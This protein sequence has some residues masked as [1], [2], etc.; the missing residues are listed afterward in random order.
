MSFFSAIEKAE[1]S[2]VAWLE[3]EITA[4]EN[5][6]PTIERVVDA[7]IAYVGPL[8]QLALTSIGAGGAAAA[9]NTVI[10]AAQAK[11]H[12]ASALITDFGPTPTAASMFSTVQTELSG[13]LSLIDVKNTT[14]VSQVTKAVNE[15]GVLAAGVQTAAAAITAAA[16]P[17]AA[18]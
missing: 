9:I 11:I 6:A 7:G 2:T 10:T 12:A 17:P 4:L 14:A 5:K 15:V 3:K 16:E 8:L 18:A 1:H 13:I